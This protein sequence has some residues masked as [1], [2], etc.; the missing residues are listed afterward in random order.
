MRARGAAVYHISIGVPRRAE[1]AGVARSKFTR[2]ARAAGHAP[3][4]RCRRVPGLSEVRAVCCN[5]GLARARLPVAHTRVLL[6]AGARRARAAAGEAA[7]SA[8]LAVPR[9][10]RAEVAGPAVTQAIAGLAGR[11]PRRSC[12]P[13]SRRSPRRCRPATVAPCSCGAATRTKSST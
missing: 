5:Y 11:A 8:R 7:A 12:R 13:A 4:L 1:K 2:L 3:A 6:G 9:R 10:G